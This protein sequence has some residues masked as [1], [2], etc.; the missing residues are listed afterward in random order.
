MNQ[1]W[2]G[3]TVCH[4]RCN[5]KWC[6]HSHMMKVLLACLIVCHWHN[7]SVAIPL[8][9]DNTPGSF[10]SWYEPGDSDLWF[11]GRAINRISGEGEFRYVFFFLMLQIAVL[12]A[13]AIQWWSI[14]S[15]KIHFD[16]PQAVVSW[17]KAKWIWMWIIVFH[18]V[19]MPMI[20]VTLFKQYQCTTVELTQ[21]NK[22]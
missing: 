22:P 11:T 1:A 19:G 9:S 21:R 16:T 4:H 10:P 18:L 8:W 20:V 2:S 3:K 12:T 15:D 6:H 7:Q 14:C 13:R 5:S 17:P